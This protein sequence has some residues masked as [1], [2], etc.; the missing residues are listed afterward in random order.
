MCWNV[1]AGSNPS[2]IEW[3]ALNLTG[4]HSFVHRDQ[5]WLVTQLMNKG[6]HIHIY[7]RIHRILFIRVMLA[8]NECLKE[9]RP[10]RRSQRRVF[11]GDSAWNSERVAV[12][13]WK[14]PNPSVHSYGYV[15]FRVFST[16]FALEILRPETFCSTVKGT[17][18]SRI[19]AF[20]DGWWRVEID[21]R[22]VRSK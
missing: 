7:I 15:S 3:I 16:K 6:Y 1:T 8:R 10:R 22:I 19:S 14:W 17:L 18:W 21:G 9:K 11:G 12:F 20:L 4:P 13:P 2:R 5:L